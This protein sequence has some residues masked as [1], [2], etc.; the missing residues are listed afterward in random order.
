M[1]ITRRPQYTII[2]TSEETPNFFFGLSRQLQMKYLY[3]TVN[4]VIENHFSTIFT[5]MAANTLELDDLYCI[6]YI[7]RFAEVC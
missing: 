5:P 7:A 6:M 1:L 2:H 4:F 3:K